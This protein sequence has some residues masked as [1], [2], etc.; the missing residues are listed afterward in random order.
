M[1]SSWLWTSRYNFGP[2][3]NLAAKFPAVF[4]E[5]HALYNAIFVRNVVR[6]LEEREMTKKDL[7]ERSGVS[8]SFVSDL[9]NRKAN[10]SLKV[11]ESIAMALDVPLP[12]LL[13]SDGSTGLPKGARSLPH[14]YERVSAVLPLAKAFV[15]KKWSEAARAKLSV[16]TGRSSRRGDAG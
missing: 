7:S 10:P 2:A 3:G 5:E 9:T 12:M 4:T 11:M 1:R 15:V 8:L 14:G 6:L 13:D 16:S